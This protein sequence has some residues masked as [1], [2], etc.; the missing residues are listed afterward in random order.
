MPT[1]QSDLVN[2]ERVNLAL[3]VVIGLGAIGHQVMRAL[4]GLG[5]QNL[6]L[7]DPQN[8]EEENVLTQGFH[9]VAVGTPKVDAACMSILAQRDGEYLE[10]AS[11]HSELGVR[12]HAANFCESLR[13][14][15]APF[16]AGMLDYLIPWESVVVF[17]CVDSMAA[18]T[19]IFEGLAALNR[20]DLFIDTRMAGNTLRVLTTQMDDAESRERYE[21]S[22]ITDAEAIQGACTGRGTLYG[23]TIAG[24]LAVSQAACALTGT[25]LPHARDVLFNLT[26][27][28]LMTNGDVALVGAGAS[29]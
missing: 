19:S 24:G 25:V 27:M 11:V 20:S 23:A 1:R 14:L 17:S 26:A 21:A 4:V 8:V 29:A 13:A 12:G 16:T 15:W 2:E 10:H 28:E 9:R 5:A 22:L 6:L 18:R 7:I 3:F